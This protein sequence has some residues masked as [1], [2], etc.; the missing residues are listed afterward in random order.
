MKLKKAVKKVED[1]IKATLI[2]C[3]FSSE[4]WTHIRTNNVIKRM[5]Q[6]IHRRTRIVDTACDFLAM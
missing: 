4:R 5:N 3:H 6:E 2:Y 1:I